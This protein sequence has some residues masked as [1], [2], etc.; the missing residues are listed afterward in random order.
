M[1]DAP[2]EQDPVLIEQPTPEPPDESTADDQP[3]KNPP[4][5]P[6]VLPPDEG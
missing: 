3:Q 5:V 2:D 6:G 4:P 1:T